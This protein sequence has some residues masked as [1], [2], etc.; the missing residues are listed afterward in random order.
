MR[1]QYSTEFKAT[2]L[3]EIYIS[4]RP[5]LKVA[6][7]YGVPIKTL[8]K[9]ITACNKDRVNYST[10]EL[11]DKELIKKLEKQVSKPRIE[12]EIL[13]KRLPCWAKRNNGL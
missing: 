2:V 5:R 6:E 7:E 3:S 10:D 11:S 12:N 13:K 4:Q 8:E 9:W 1:K